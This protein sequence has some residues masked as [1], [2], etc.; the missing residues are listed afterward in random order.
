MH[1]FGTISHFVH[2]SDKLKSLF[3]LIIPKFKSKKWV[4]TADTFIDLTQSTTF[5][6][7]NELDFLFGGD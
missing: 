6:E 3:Q 1:H 7:S 4:P 5:G 2:Y